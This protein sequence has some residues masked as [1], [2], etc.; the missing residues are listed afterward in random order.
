M[1]RSGD[2]DWLWLSLGA[3]ACVVSGVIFG[4]VSERQ[5]NT[6]NR[7]S[8]IRLEDIK[9]DTCDEDET[10]DGETIIKR[11]RDSNWHRE[12]IEF[13]DGLD[14]ENVSDVQL[15]TLVC[16]LILALE[17][18]I[19][20]FKTVCDRFRSIR[21]VVQVFAE[22]QKVNSAALP[23]LKSFTR[24]KLKMELEKHEIRVE[25]Q[26]YSHC[27]S[28]LASHGTCAEIVGSIAVNFPVRWIALRKLGDGLQKS[29]K[30][31]NQE[32]AFINILAQPLPSFDERIVKALD[33]ALQQDVVPNWMKIERNGKVLQASEKLFWNTLIKKRWQPKEQTKKPSVHPDEEDVYWEGVKVTKVPSING[34]Y[35]QIITPIKRKWKSSRI[36]QK[37]GGRR[38][39]NNL[40]LLTAYRSVSVPSTLYLDRVSSMSAAEVDSEIDEMKR[41]MHRLS[42][43]FNALQDSREEKSQSLESSSIQEAGLNRLQDAELCIGP[44]AMEEE[45]NI[46]DVCKKQKTINLEG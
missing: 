45:D 18:N 36:S 23:L 13:L 14:F 35:P 32:I 30:W 9:V 17:K 6:Q 2:R 15:K 25:A 3:A 29:K 34:E 4:T 5:I 46:Q 8:S 28:F 1:A 22:I 42:A 37:I 31:S 27:F 39:N 19:L 33:V 44:T 43:D 40:N 26:S 21:E 38:G 20:S 10:E 12:I 24:D 11:L 16:E 41:H 7:T